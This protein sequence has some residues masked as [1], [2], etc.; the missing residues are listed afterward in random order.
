[1]LCDE[2]VYPLIFSTGSGGCG[3]LQSEKPEGTAP[4]IRKV[5]ISLI[6]QSRDHL[7]HQLTTLRKEFICAVYS[8]LIKLKMRSLVQAQKRC[9]AKEDEIRAGD[10]KDSSS[11]SRYERPASRNRPILQLSRSPKGGRGNRLCKGT[12]QPGLSGDRGGS[13]PAAGIPETRAG[14][15]ISSQNDRTKQANLREQRRVL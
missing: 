12:R 2:F 9:L 4:L 6:L 13:N 3:I 8:C 7:I 10:S 1:M 15:Q 11:I 5:F 14:M